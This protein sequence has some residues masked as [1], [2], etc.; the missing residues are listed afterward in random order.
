MRRSPNEE[1]PRAGQEA[2]WHGLLALVPR[3]TPPAHLTARILAATR[4]AWPA[5]PRAQDVGA[6]TEVA[7]TAGVLTGAALLTLGPVAVVLA[8]FFLDTGLI[9]GSI[10]RLFVFTV[11]WLNT[12]VSI[13]DVLSRA[14]RIVGAAIASPAG[15]VI[16]AG[17]LLTASL[18]LAGLSRWLPHERGEV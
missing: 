1:T 11:D 5:T 7:V 16:M 17:G 15:T 8:F 9:V 12:G 13:W 18:A 3:R 4:P 2:Q 14:A 10:A 6:S